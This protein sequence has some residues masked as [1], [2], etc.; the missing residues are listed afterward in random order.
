MLSERQ[1][2]ILWHV[3]DGYLRTGMPVGS[4]AIAQDPTIACGPSTIRSELAL[5][6]EHGL[7]DHPHTS[8]GRVPTEAGQ[9]FIVDRLLAGQDE[10]PGPGALHIEL[11]R[12]EVDAAMRATTESLSQMT[13]LLAVVSAPTISTASIRHVEVL[14]LQ[15][16]AVLVVVI[17]STG[18]VSKMI[19]TF[20]TPV[21]AGLV[22]WAGEYLN[23]RLVGLPIGA[24]MVQQR[25]SDAS[26]P[27]REREFLAR[28]AA[29]FAELTDEGQDRIY[30]DGTARLFEA[31]VIDGTGPVH[32]LIELL[33]RRA[34]LLNVLR[35][36]LG[37]HGVYVRIGSENELPALRSLAIV[38]SGYG[39]A[40]TRAGTVSLIGPVHM[41]YAG[42]IG[43]VRDAARQLSSFV[44]DADAAE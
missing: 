12:R 10:L 11:M 38:A 34:A 28:F 30:F 37:E 39:L 17:T 16:D 8:A 24:R 44:Q 13:N 22:A 29:G 19:A 3:V 1:E 36:A 35:A 25:V 42:A 27:D 41:D 5:L 26:L 43:A 9:R 31:G 15:P 33:E 32:E 23:E 18:N 4:R 14:A 20:Q 2:R 7:L 6:E 21:D 40:P